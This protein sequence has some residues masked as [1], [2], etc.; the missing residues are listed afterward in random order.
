MSERRREVD[1]LFVARATLCDLLRGQ[2]LRA[3]A[4]RA[5]DDA[6]YT[7]A[8]RLEVTALWTERGQLPYWERWSRHGTCP[9]VV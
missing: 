2:S 8:Q 9:V 5:R 4:A 7:R 1:P 3:L 6:D